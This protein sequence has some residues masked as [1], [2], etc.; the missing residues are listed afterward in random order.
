MRRKMNTANLYHTFM[1]IVCMYSCITGYSL[2]FF[3]IAN[4]NIDI[5]K[6][7]VYYIFMIA[8]DRKH[9]DVLNRKCCF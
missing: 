3:S 4:Q 8:L 9:S 1:T 2:F 7:I 6:S 5:C